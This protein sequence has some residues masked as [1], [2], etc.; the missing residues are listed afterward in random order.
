M[1]ITRRECG[2]ECGHEHYTNAH[3]ALACSREFC[4]N[5]GPSPAVKR[6]ERSSSNFV[7]TSTG[8]C[9]SDLYALKSRCVATDKTRYALISLSCPPRTDIRCIH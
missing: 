7:F 3:A 2:S 5:K 6:M 9:A 4:Y 8:S 1:I